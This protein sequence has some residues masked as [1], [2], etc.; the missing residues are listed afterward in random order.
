MTKVNS[1]GISLPTEIISKVD[2]E[3]GDVP[4][5]RYILRVLRETLFKKTKLGS[6][7]ATKSNISKDS[8]DHR[9]ETLQSGESRSLSEFANSMG[10]ISKFTQVNKNLCDGNGCSRAATTEIE[11]NVG[12]LGIIKLNLCENCIPRFKKSITKETGA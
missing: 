6:S 5:S 2:A 12:E 7:N 3:R 1:V 11:V 9:H 10:Q 4:R 8:P